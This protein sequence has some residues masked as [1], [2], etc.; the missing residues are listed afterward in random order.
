M[1]AISVQGG[2][3]DLPMSGMAEAAL[4]FF[5]LTGGPTPTLTPTPTPTGVPEPAASPTP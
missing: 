3:H 1:E 5:G 4:R 2:G